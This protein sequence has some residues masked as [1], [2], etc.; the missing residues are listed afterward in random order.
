[1]RR[2]VDRQAATDFLMGHLTIGLSIAFNVF[3]EGRFSDGALYAIAKAKSE[4]FR[5]GWLERVFSHDAV[6][7]SVREICQ[8]PKAA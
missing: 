1:V 4:I 7:Q 8:P 2:G 3:P 5:D 6:M